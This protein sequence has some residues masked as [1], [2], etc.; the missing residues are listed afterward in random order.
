MQVYV[1]YDECKDSPRPGVVACFS[2]SST[3]V[4]RGFVLGV[5]EVHM[6]TVWMQSLYIG[7]RGPEACALYY[8]AMIAA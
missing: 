3:Q 7:P 8:H 5:S 2:G 4:S 1:K 6:G